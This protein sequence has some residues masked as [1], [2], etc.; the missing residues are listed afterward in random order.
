[1]CHMIAN[2]VHPVESI[3]QIIYHKGVC[4]RI[5]FNSKNSWGESILYLAAKAG[6]T[7]LVDTLLTRIVG[8]D[9]NIQ[10][11]D[12]MTPLMLACAYGHHSIIELLLKQ[13]DIDVNLKNQNGECAL[14]ACTGSSDRKQSP[15]SISKQ[16]CR[17]LLAHPNVDVNVRTSNG[18]TPLISAVYAQNFELVQLLVDHKD[19]K[20][21]IRQNGD[22]HA[23]TIALLN[24]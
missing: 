18:N 20:L 14:I 15:S 8:I 16:T 9:V 23:L 17:L 22:N 13:D 19:I 10:T 1:M 2:A 5:N 6:E 21:N 24:E 7:E 3:N 12:G 11:V 4:S